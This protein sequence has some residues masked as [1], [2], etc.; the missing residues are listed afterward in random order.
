[1]R[2]YSH[3]FVSPH[4]FSR[5]WCVYELATFCN[6]NKM[7][8]DPA[9]E[10]R[11]MLINLEWP[12]TLAPFK[13]DK[14]ADIELSWFTNFR[15]RR[16]RCFKPSDRSVVLASIREAW[17]SEDKFDQFVANELPYTLRRS[18]MQYSK[19]LTTVLLSRLELVFGD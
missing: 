1:M 5:L 18:K 8:T 3:V 16:A 10:A 14:L 13:S 12:G 6:D 2:E 17:G 11:L 19:Q 7:H 9:P 4:Y 15:C